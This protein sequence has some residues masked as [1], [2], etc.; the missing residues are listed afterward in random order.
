[1]AESKNKS[2]EGT[3]RGDLAAFVGICLLG[4]LIYAHT[5]QV[6]WY[7][8]DVRAI[9]ENR[10]IHQLSEAWEDLFSG[11]GFANLT[12][13][14]NYHYGGTKVVGYH[15]VNIVIHLVTSCLVFL[16]F[17]RVFPSRYL[18]ALGGALIFVAHP[19]QTQAVTYIV[20]RMTSLA[21]LFF[22]LAL[23]LY[24]R[25]RENTDHKESRHWV[26]YGSAI[27]CGVLAVF[28]K[29]NTAVLP[30]AIILFDRYFLAEERRLSWSRQFW[31]VAPFAIAPIGLAVTSL[32]LPAL[33]G[34]GI[35]NVGGMPDLVHLR[36]LSPLNYLATEFSVIWLYLRLLFVPYGQA[37]DYDIPIV[38]TVWEAKT[39]IAALGVVALLA[40]A[41]YM[42]KRLP[43]LSAGILWFFLGLAVESTIIPLDPVFEHRLYIPMFGFALV[44]MAAL[45]R[46]PG[47]GAWVG[48]FLL[49]AALSVL[50]WQRNDL[51]NDPAAFYE[52]NLRRAPRSERVH[53]DLANVYRKQGRLEEAQQL[54]E[55]ALEIN[56]DYVLLHINLSMV[57][58]AQKQHKKAVQILLEGVRRNPSHF[59][60]YNNLGVLY[61]FQGKYAEAAA[62]LQ[63]GLMLEPY[64][65]TVYFNLALAYERLGRLEDAIYH[66]RRSLELDRSDPMTYFNLG[67]ALNKKG[68]LKEALQAFLVA[69][70]LNPN[71]AGTLY[72][73]GLTYLDL[74]D[75]AS[76]LNLLPRLSV[77]NPEM[78]K[79]LQLRISELR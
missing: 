66:Y 8:D 22:F 73:V 10:T 69:A 35:A 74:R 34:E 27:V 53:L 63:K 56:P 20:Q 61:N 62:Y 42:R 25:A 31:Y 19:L 52:D 21:A 40:T 54:Y 18:L 49:V 30:V 76:A 24:V 46:L 64:N 14:F 28:F 51:W 68:E 17:K 55:R 72:N 41:A 43:Y 16:L 4:I 5:L 65:A 78:A 67:V 26:F 75:V 57:Y 79:R 48:T 37:L 23:Y 33:S 1:M 77:L 58:A 15:I 59:K 36:H 11:R 32:L 9:V 2:W 44:V 29:Q 71:H 7:M 12:F 38:A 47:R 45:A 13:A 60:L 50:T 70:Q 6:P 39:L 3:G